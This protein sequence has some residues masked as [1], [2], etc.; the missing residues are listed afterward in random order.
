[1]II[2]LEIAE[3]SQYFVQDMWVVNDVNVRI[4]IN[5]LGEIVGIDA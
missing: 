3:I 5:M 4:N 1:M 2:G